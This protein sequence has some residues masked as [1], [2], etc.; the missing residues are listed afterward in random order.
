MQI[1]NAALALKRF[2]EARQGAL[3]VVDAVSYLVAAISASQAAEDM[4]DFETAYAR[5]AIAWASLSDLLDANTAA[6]MIRPEL[7]G[8]RE[9]LGTDDFTAA[10]HQY[11]KKRRSM[12]TQT[13]K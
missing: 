2:D 13:K 5:L 1:G 6:Q 7:E 4:G 10:K 3:D 9:R 12:R 8:L 11:E